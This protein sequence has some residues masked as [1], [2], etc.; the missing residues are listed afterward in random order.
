MTV[1]GFWRMALFGKWMRARE[2]GHTKKDDNR[3]VRPFAWG[4]EFISDHVNGDDPRV[5]LREYTRQAMADSE[6]F[7]ALPEINDYKLVD[8]QLSWT[9]AIQ[10]TSPEI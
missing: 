10:T 4:L 1:R 3:I 9:S 8:D 2:I 5:L 7:Y 6:A